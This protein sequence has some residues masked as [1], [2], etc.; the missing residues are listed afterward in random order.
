MLTAEAWLSGEPKSWDCV[1]I[2]NNVGSSV[3]K[4]KVG[5][6]AFSIKDE[7]VPGV[8][9]HLCAT[10]LTATNR[11][12]PVGDVADLYIDCSDDKSSVSICFQP[13]P[14]IR[15][16]HVITFPRSQ[17]RSFLQVVKE[18]LLIYGALDRWPE[19]EM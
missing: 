7:L 9:S 6:T 16:W 15:G 10:G 1:A 8:V 5:V 14:R 3:G 12:P 17:S 18:Q 19:H 13:N 4:A 11:E 2:V